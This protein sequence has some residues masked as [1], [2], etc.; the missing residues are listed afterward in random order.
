MYIPLIFLNCPSVSPAVPTQPVLPTVAVPAS[1]RRWGH[2]LL[3]VVGLLAV[4]IWAGLTFWL[5]PWLRRTLQEKV[6][7][8]SHGRYQLRIGEL[9]TSLWHRRAALR[10]LHLRTVGSTTDSVRLPRVEAALGRLQIAGIGLWQLL[11]R[12]EVSLDSVALDAVTVQLSGWP[13]TASSLPLHRQ[14]PVQGLRIGKL[15]VRHAQGLFGPAA[16]P[17]VQV[18]DADLLFRDVRIGAA[19]AADS[20]RIGYAAAVAVE[21]RNLMAQVPGHQLRLRR[22]VAASGS[23]RLEADSMTIHPLQS[24]NSRRS[25]NVRVSLALPRVVL[26]G[27][28]AAGLTR[29]QFQADSLWVASPRMALTLPARKPPALHDAL[30]PYLRQCQLKTLVVTNGQVRIAGTELAPAVADVHITGS[31]VQVLPYAGRPVG[32]YYAQAWRV[33][34]GRATATLNA[35]YYHLAWQRLRAD[36]RAGRLQLTNIA[37]MPTMSVVRLAQSKGHQAAHITARVS[38]LALTGLDFPAVLNQAEFRAATFTLRAPR[39]T[40]RSDGRFPINPAI[41]RVTPEALGRVPFRFALQ[42][43]QVRQATITMLY[44]SPRSPQPGTL[45]ITRFGGTLRNLSNDPRRMNAAHPLTGEASGRLQDQCVARLT[46]RANLLDPAGRHTV[47]G[48]FGAA[49]L[50]ILN[51]MTVPTRGLGFRSGQIN[52][53]RFQ[54]ELSQAAAEGTMWGHYTDLKLQL[55]NRQ[56]KPGRLHRVG[57]SLVNGILI[58]DDNPR[59]PG[60]PLQPGRMSSGRERRFSVFSLWRQ[61][62]VSGLLNSAGVPSGLAKKL[63]EGE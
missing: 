47:T 4:G 21:V 16:S 15:V 6:Q 33:Q 61:G 14:L 57:T 30:I 58:R 23:R 52:R 8:A 50:A 53:I 56:N 13:P 55:L 43:L 32:M 11:R 27:V 17:A 19:G 5:D 37:L 34:T 62:L 7:T 31:R 44:R 49:P 18:G 51:A 12:G 24:I 63:S 3:V 39:V 2:W 26:T 28:D 54:M 60:Q 25:P 29:R 9:H 45:Q 1:R 10:R 35:P 38:E 48:V 59:Q 42:Q 22:L 41:S 46:L 20:S 36:T 40:T